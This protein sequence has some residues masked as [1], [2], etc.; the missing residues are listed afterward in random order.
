MVRTIASFSL[1]SAMLAAGLLDAAREQ[2]VPFDPAVICA[3]QNQTIGPSAKGSAVVR[4]QI[5]LDRA[6]FSYGQMD[7]DC[8]TNLQAVLNAD[9]AW[10]LITYTIDAQDLAGPFV[11]VP[12]E[13]MQQGKLPA[14][15]YASPV[16]ELSEKFHE[17]SALLEAL[18][19]AK[20]FG[21]AGEQILVTNAIT[22]ASEAAVSVVVS[23]SDRSVTTYDAQGKILAYYVATVGEHDPL[24]IG[25]WK[26]N[27]VARNP[28]FHYDPQLF[29]DANPKDEKTAIQPGPR[30]PAGVVWIDLSKD[31]SGIHGTPD[32]SEIGHAES[33]GCIRLTNWDAPQLADMV[34]PGT[35]ATLKE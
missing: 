35:P 17:S 8:G 4:A 2:A 1:A 34:K 25:D 24:P 5:L 28:V 29:W 12:S 26:I 13:M 21:K 10:V 18:N 15:G 27:G 7:G 23:K 19:T 20:D 31:H 30:N 11:N 14:L 33:H 3:V 16:D 22:I 6:R 32:P 9:T